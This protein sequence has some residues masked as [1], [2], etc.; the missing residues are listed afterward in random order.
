MNLPLSG[1]GLTRC[2][3]L[4]MESEKLTVGKALV[5]PWSSLYCLVRRGLLV[6]TS[7]PSKRL[8]PFYFP[9][10]RG[11]FVRLFEVARAVARIST[12]L[13]LLTNPA[14]SSSPHRCTMKGTNYLTAQHE[15]E[16]R[17]MS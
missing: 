11:G 13:L 2:G 5:L 16:W 14:Q 7:L 1:I 12:G 15:C 4:A 10:R 17:S 6:V 9:R 8:Q 3:M